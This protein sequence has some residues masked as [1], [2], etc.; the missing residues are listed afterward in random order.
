MCVPALPFLTGS[1]FGFFGS[2]TGMTAA[3]S[4]SSAIASAFTRDT[5]C[6]FT[7]G[8][9]FPGDQNRLFKVY[10]P[11]DLGSSNHQMK[12]QFCLQLISVK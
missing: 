6:A 2:D 3:L 1:T 10:K 12:S 7:E 5:L 9:P 11:N 8:K 4:Q